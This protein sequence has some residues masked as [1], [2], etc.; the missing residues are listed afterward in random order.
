MALFEHRQK[1]KAPNYSVPPKMSVFAIVELH[2]YDS[3]VTNKILS[4]SFLSGLS[5]TVL[6]YKHAMLG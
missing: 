5:A 4:G 3:H 1:H 6:V 2:F